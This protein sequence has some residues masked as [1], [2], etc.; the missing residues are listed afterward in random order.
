M[1]K[2]IKASTALTLIEWPVVITIINL[3]VLILVPT[4]GGTNCLHAASSHSGSMDETRSCRTC[5]AH[6]E[7]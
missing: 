3:L 6:N 4:I 1:I 5:G 2:S 7:L